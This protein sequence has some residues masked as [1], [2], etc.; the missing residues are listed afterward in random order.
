MPIVYVAGK[1]SSIVKLKDK[2][3]PYSEW[4]DKDLA[5]QREEYEKPNLSLWL[6]IENKEDEVS[7]FAI[8]VTN[9]DVYEGSINCT[10]SGMS[11]TLEF[12]GKAKV[13]VH[14]DTKAAIDKGEK[15]KAIG[16]AVNGASQDFEEPLEVQLAVQSKK[17]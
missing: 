16:M 6:E 14:K 13:N 2:D 11:F 9:L 10:Q 12:D 4:V 1:F 8:P 5:K 3:Y 7:P 15:P 17:I